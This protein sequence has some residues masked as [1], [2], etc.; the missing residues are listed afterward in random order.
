MNQW[1]GDS[2][3]VRTDSG[4]A[5]SPLDKPVAVPSILIGTPNAVSKQRRSVSL[6]DST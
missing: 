4:E 5:D 1:G 3:F 2:S 6:D